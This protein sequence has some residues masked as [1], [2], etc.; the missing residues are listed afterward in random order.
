M[1]EILLSNKNGFK[2]SPGLICFVCLW[3]LLMRNT[4]LNLFHAMHCSGRSLDMRGESEEQEVKR[5]KCRAER[6]EKKVKKAK[7]RKLGVESEEKRR[8]SRKVP[9]GLG[10]EQNRRCGCLPNL[11]KHIQGWLQP[12]STPP[13]EAQHV[14][15]CR[16]IPAASVRLF[17]CNERTLVN[18]CDFF[19][20]RRCTHLN[21]KASSPENNLYLLDCFFSVN[22]A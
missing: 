5:G 12:P 19:T 3:F 16:V 2:V 6:E 4:G 9:Q 10:Q 17:L 15:V 11:C 21:P 22:S 8:K 1:E 13:V 20:I 7:S 18:Y 14:Q